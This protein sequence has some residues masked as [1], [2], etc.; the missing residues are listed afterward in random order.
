VEADEPSAGDVASIESCRL[1]A[2]LWMDDGVLFFHYDANSEEC[3]LY[4]TLEADC[5]SV[6]GPR[7][8]PPFEQCTTTT[9]TT[10]TTAATTTTTITTTT[11]TTAST[12]TIIATTTTTTTTSTTTTIATTTTTT[13]MPYP[14]ALLIVGGWGRWGFPSEI[15]SPEFDTCALERF[16]DETKEYFTLENVENV[17]VSC[18][19]HKC[20]KLERGY[21]TFLTSTLV[22]R[23]Y[24]TSAVLNSEILLIGGSTDPSSTEWIPLDGS[25]ARLGFTINPGR[26]H[27]CSIQPSPNIVILTGGTGTW[28]LVTEIV[29][30][31]GTSTTNLPSL[32]S[33]RQDHAC[34]SYEY[35][36][37]QTLIVTGGI[38]RSS[39]TRL[40]STE[41]YNS[42]MSNGAWREVGQLPNERYYLNGITLNGIFYV[43]G[44]TD[45]G[46][47][48]TNEVLAWDSES[49]TW[50]RSGH[51]R[52][53][54]SAHAVT[55]IRYTD[56]E[57]YCH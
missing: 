50:N 34:G 57:Q 27:H 25:E 8:A 16:G 4:R 43:T 21:W 44:G 13:S 3:H 28:N 29:L 42:G 52:E 56:M 24:H 32:N 51:M 12:T 48:D 19:D 10:T 26:T 2:E 55:L 53:P 39:S 22:S 49:E 41:V 11:T 40:S 1:W 17:V 18:L 54:R 23:S 6:G 14:D 9:T 46:G 7:V 20:E 15:W 33:A 5:A 38:Q 45:G 37:R 31:D 47:F 30:P 35:Q 36:G